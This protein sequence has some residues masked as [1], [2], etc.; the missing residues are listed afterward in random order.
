M[1]LSRFAAALLVLV[2]VVPTT[3]FAQAEPEGTLDADIL[4]SYYDQD[5]DHSPVTGGLGTEKLEVVSP[6][7]VLAWRVSEDLTLSAD[8]G[9]DQVSSASMGN[10]QMELSS[11]SIP[12]S[13]TRTFGTFKAKRKFGR[14]TFG[15]TVGAATEYDYESFSYGID[16]A[17]EFNQANTGLS[18]AIRRFD[19]AIDLIGIDGY[20]AQGDGTF[21]EG[22]GDRT[23]TDAT[24]TLSQTLG[25]RTA[26]SIEL[27]VS[28]QEGVLSTPYHEVIIG[29]GSLLDPGTHVAERLPETRDRQAVSLRLTH[30]FSDRIVQRVG[31]RFYTDD[32][33][34]DAHTIDL[35]THFRLPSEREMWLYPILRHHTQTGAD[36][37]GL[38]RT[39]SGS[40]AYYTSDWD[41]AETA[42]DKYGIGWSVTTLPREKMLLHVDRL[43]MRATFYDRDDGLS[44]FTTSLGFG[45][46]F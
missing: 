4:F 33:G 19:D 16:W 25:R 38:P 28:Q 45:W 3:A 23:T 15:L 17:T 41:L 14:Q 8:V 31:Y 32:W 29:E 42:S 27:F 34:I 6:V 21:T 13:D 7:I 20:G 1:Q 11:A 18:A 43:E 39:F 9:I 46:T 26:G 30:S 36:Y 40:E 44:G 10:I 37:F 22:K 2:F 12:A 35:E 5:G 24:F